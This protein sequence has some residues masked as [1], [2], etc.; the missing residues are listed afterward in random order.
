MNKNITCPVHGRLAKLEFQESP[1]SSRVLGATKCS[2]IEGEVDCE[3]EC[4]RLM[5]VKRTAEMRAQPAPDDTA[6][7]DTAMQEDEANEERS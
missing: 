1:E 2:L 6:P 4:V 3:Q 5:N 7:D